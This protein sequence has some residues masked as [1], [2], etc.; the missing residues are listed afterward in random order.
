MCLCVCHMLFL[1]VAFVGLDFSLNLF[2]LGFLKASLSLLVHWPEVGG[3][4][5]YRKRV[6]W[7]CLEVVLGSTLLFVVRVPAV[8]SNSKHQTGIS[9]SGSSLQKPQ[10]STESLWV[11]ESGKNQL[12]YHKKFAGVFLSIKWRPV[13]KWE[14]RNISGS[15]KPSEDQGGVARH[16]HARASFTVYGVS[17]ILLP[18]IVY[19]LKHLLQKNI[20][21]SLVCLLHQN[22]LS[23]DSFQQNITWHNRVSKETRDLHFKP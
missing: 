16:C 12:E 22:I 14:Q 15:A 7:T 1:W 10:G 3:K 20:T 6:L 19:H 2:Y 4:M 17:F 13:K 11:N 23:Q 21:C 18:N 8:Q 5:V 9:R